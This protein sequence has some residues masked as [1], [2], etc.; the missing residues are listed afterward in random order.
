MTDRAKRRSRGQA[1]TT[2]IKKARLG[3]R[4]VDRYGTVD[5]DSFALVDLQRASKPTLRRELRIKSAVAESLIEQRKRMSLTPAALARAQ[6][7]L[8]SALASCTAAPFMP[9]RHLCTLSMWF[10][11]RTA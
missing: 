5:S 6:P 3:S 4:P 10:P 1:A 9:M 11:R 8:P 7:R 2:V